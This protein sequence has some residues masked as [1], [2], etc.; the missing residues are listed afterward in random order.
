MKE[1]KKNGF[2]YVLHTYSEYDLMFR[3][4]TLMEIVKISHEAGLEVWVNPWGVGNVFGG[5]PFSNF[6]NQN[7]F[8]SCQVLDDGNPTAIA[9]P[10]SPM[11]NDYMVK[12]LNAVSAA[13][14][15]A[16]LWDEPHFH[17]QGFLSSVEGRWGCRCKYCKAKYEEL[18]NTEMPLNETDSVKLFKLKSILKFITN[19]ADKAKKLGIKNTLY[20]TANLK[21]NKIITAWDD[22]AKIESI[23]TIATGP[24]W[25]WA[26]EEVG[27]VNEYSRV[28]QRLAKKYNKESQVWIQGFNIHA[29]LESEIRQ[30]TQFVNEAEVDRIA[31]WGYEGCTQQSWIS[32]DNPTLVWRTILESIKSSKQ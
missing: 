18:F 24:Y 7:I 3:E 10:N 5:E 4:K 23:D 25:Q 26:K 14:V 21:P 22:Y 31:F 8:S 2:N 19:L 32:C 9:C 17:E 12:W 16:I 27:I 29:Q 15:D 11:F 20:L 1:L 6:V 13:K 28:I 30:A